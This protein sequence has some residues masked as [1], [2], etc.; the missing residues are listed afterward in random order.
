MKMM[1]ETVRDKGWMKR[2]QE[3]KTGIERLITGVICE[4]TEGKHP[5]IYEGYPNKA[6]Y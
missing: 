6:F 2:V 1:D 5:H 3:V 4:P